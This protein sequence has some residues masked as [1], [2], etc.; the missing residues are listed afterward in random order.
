M[1]NS[2]FP[3]HIMLRRFFLNKFFILFTSVILV[4]VGCQSQPEI[5]ESVYLNGAGATFPLFLYQKWF[6]EYS[7]QHPN[8]QLNYQ[9][10]GSAAGIQQVVSET[11]DFGASDVAMTDEE[12]EKVSKG[13][14][15]LPMTAGSVVITYNLPGIET[16][17]KLSR[18]V[19]SDIFLGKINR[20][21]DSKIKALNPDINLPDLPILVVHRSDGSGTTAVFTKHLSAI[22][23]EWKNKVGSGVNVEWVAGVAMKSSSGVSAQIQQQPGTIGYIESTYAQESNLSTAALQNK[24]GNYIQSNT[25][26]VT[27]ALRSKP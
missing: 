13:V 15:L 26:T 12:I 6:Q 25:K 19:Y 17:L 10:I 5:S 9:A 27:E 21:N 16:G 8:V 2:L 3:I 23:S 11:I 24:A 20:W 18:E 1:P 22:S 7:Q 4:I 14:V